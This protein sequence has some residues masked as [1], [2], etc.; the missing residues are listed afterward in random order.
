MSCLQGTDDGKDILVNVGSG[1]SDAPRETFWETKDRLLGMVA[2]VRADA[3]YR[4]QDGTYSLRF[5]CPKTFRG[6]EVGEKI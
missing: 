6:F 3:A 5:P 1:P 4:T 2:E